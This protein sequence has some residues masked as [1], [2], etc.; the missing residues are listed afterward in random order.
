MRHMCKLHLSRC[1]HGMVRRVTNEHYPQEGIVQL[2]Q[3]LWEKIF[4]IIILKIMISFNFTKRSRDHWSVHYRGARGVEF[5][6]FKTTRWRMIKATN[7]IVNRSL[8]WFLDYSSQRAK[9]NNCIFIIFLSLGLIIYGP[10]HIRN[11]KAK[12]LKPGR[13]YRALDNINYKQILVIPSDDKVE[14]FLCWFPVIARLTV[15]ASSLLVWTVSREVPYELKLRK[16]V[17]DDCKKVCRAFSALP[18]LFNEESLL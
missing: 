12:H 13:P 9:L 17:A 14:D 5:F 11:L 1:A 8:K 4:E 7:E 2:I 18:I 10:R 15:L 6:S 16:L 3:H